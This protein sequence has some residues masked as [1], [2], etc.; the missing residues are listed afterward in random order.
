M[1]DVTRTPRGWLTTPTRT[2]LDIARAA[3]RD[4]AVC[5]ID[6]LLHRRRTDLAELDQRLAGM[7]SWP[8]ALHARHVLSLVSGTSESPGE[9]LCRLMF[10]D[11]R[12]PAPVPQYEIRDHAGR[13][14]GR[15]DFAWPEHGVV[16]EFDGKSKYQQHRR[17][18]ERLE[19]CI[20]RE[21]RRED[22]VREVT[23][24]TVIRLTWADLHSPARTTARLLAALA[25]AAA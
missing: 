22:R 21:K 8:G 11:Q 7:S 17:A 18:E 15:V 14:I 24:W 13:F 6:D 4:T 2:A 10:K 1:G 19:D 16:V 23:G 5:V 9:S 3:P 20:L 25:R 12:L